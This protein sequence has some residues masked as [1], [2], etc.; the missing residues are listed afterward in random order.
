MRALQNDMVASLG[1]VRTVCDNVARAHI[2]RCSRLKEATGA[3]ICGDLVAERMWRRGQHVV[4]RAS[5]CIYFISRWG[6][7]DMQLNLMSEH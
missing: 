7:S 5:Q 3:S 6:W 1:R 4:E 2:N